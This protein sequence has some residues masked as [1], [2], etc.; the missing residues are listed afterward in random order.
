VRMGFFD[1]PPQPV[2]FQL[3]QETLQKFRL[4]AEGG[5]SRLRRKRIGS[6]FWRGFTA[7]GMVRARRGVGG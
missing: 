4:S 7:A 5:A 6:A 1:T 2:T 3:H